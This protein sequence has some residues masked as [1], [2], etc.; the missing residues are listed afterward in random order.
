MTAFQQAKSVGA[1]CPLATITMKKVK[2]QFT[3]MARPGSTD[4]LKQPLGQPGYL[5]PLNLLYLEIQV[6]SFHP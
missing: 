1:R 4:V 5:Q 2:R 6:I 3:L